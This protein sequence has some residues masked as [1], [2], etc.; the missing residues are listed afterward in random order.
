[1]TPFGALNNVVDVEENRQPSSETPPHGNQ[2]KIQFH[3]EK[4]VLHDKTDFSIEIKSRRPFAEST[5]IQI[6]YNGKDVTKAF[7]KN[8][9]LHRG[10]DSRRLLYLFKDMRLKT[11]DTNNIQVQVLD[12]EGQG[13]ITRFFEEPDCSLFDQRKLAHL[14]EFHAPEHYIDMIEKVSLQKETNP[15]FLAGVVAQESGFDPSAVSW[16]KAIGLTQI[17]PLAESQVLESVDEWPRYPGINSLSYLTLKSKIFIGEIDREKEWRLNPEKSLIGGLT[18][19]Q[20]LKKYWS[21]DENRKLVEELGGNKNK[22]LTELILASY[23]SGASR[24]KRAVQT[25]KHD[26][27][28]QENLQEAVKYLKKVSS[29][30]YHYTKKEVHDD[31]ET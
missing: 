9:H 21:L 24:V 20:Y 12:E 19:F 28:K 15:S 6:S 30:C 13:V 25:R 18:Y 7:M 10:N 29:Y 5:K 22:H 3:P 16:A 14:G 27:K 26:W 1:M 8:A 23:N 4:Q 31:N 17:T 2:Y 11:L